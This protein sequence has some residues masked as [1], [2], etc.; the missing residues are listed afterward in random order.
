MRRN[1]RG[2][3]V[4]FRELQHA[5]IVYSVLYT[6]AKRGDGLVIQTGR[7]VQAQ[8]EAPQVTD[9]EQKRSSATATTSA[10]SPTSSPRRTDVTE[11]RHALAELLEVASDCRV[12]VSRTG[13]ATLTVKTPGGTFHLT[14]KRG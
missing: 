14:T 6:E 9:L 11:F 7:G 12:L 3:I 4:G 13:D 5:S 1:G 8:P 10:P 2:A